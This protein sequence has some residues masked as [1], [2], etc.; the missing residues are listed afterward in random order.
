M[1]TTK[2]IRFE[3]LKDEM[4]VYMVVP[5]WCPNF[6]TATVRQFQKGFSIEFNKKIQGNEWS[7]FVKNQKEL[8]NNWFVCTLKKYKNDEQTTNSEAEDHAKHLLALTGK[9]TWN[10]FHFSE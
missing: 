4:K 2:T 8:D 3:E 5:W 9:S 1:T 7:I 6:L 10:E